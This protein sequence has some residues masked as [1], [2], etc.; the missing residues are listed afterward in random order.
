MQPV[1]TGAEK[2]TTLSPSVSEL[3]LT[4]DPETSALSSNSVCVTSTSVSLNQADSR[5]SGRNPV[6]SKRH[7]QMNEID[8]KCKNKTTASTDIE[9][10]NIPSTTPEWTIASHD[11][12]LK[13]DLGKDWTACVQAWFELEHEL[14]YGF[15]AGAKVCVLIFFSL[16]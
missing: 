16:S 9:K 2:G 6:P 14:G 5:R 3:P 11:H 15:L 4:G 13:S 1:H 8:G 12:L 10:E 7:E